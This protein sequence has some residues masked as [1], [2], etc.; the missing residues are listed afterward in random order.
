LTF[1]K[2]PIMFQTLLLVIHKI[3]IDN[4]FIIAI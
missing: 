4:D 3:V 1:Y 2:T